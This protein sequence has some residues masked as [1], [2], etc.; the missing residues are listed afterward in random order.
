MPWEP[1]EPGAG[2][3]A[4]VAGVGPLALALDSLNRRYGSGTVGSG[5]L[6]P[7]PGLATGV[8]PLDGIT[9][10]QGLPRGR[11]SQLRG[12]PSSGAFELG[13]AVAAAVSRSANLVVVDFTAEL[14]PGS[15]AAYQGE[16]A[17]CWLVRPRRSEE[18]WAAARALARVG[19][20]LCLLVGDDWSR[21]TP[22]AA[23]SQLL[24]ALV[25]G[26]AAA[27]VLAGRGV[28][29]QLRERICL[30]LECR[31]LEWVLAHGD[32]CGLKLGVR[33][34]RSHL[35][36]PGAGC[37]LQLD[38]PRPYQTLVGAR[39]LAEVADGEGR[40]PWKRLRLAAG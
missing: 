12:G 31:R 13:M 9:A 1:V 6:T 18:G 17:N 35:A 14:D 19:V 36:A 16:L 5:A 38:F 28:P 4:S 40:S 3:E 34:G 20:D 32:V 10:C 39:Q 2:G 26:G 15:I 11:I 22:E 27:L 29:A 23:P 24:R 33:V 21:L 25:S 7:P 30:E 8:A 37:W